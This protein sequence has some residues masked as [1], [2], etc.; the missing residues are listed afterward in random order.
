LAVSSERIQTTAEHV[1]GASHLRRLDADEALRDAKRIAG[2]A[3]R[4]CAVALE[5]VATLEE[6]ASTANE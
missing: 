4:V 3:Q 1:S 6:F 5:L 2:E